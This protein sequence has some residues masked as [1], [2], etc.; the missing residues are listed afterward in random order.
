MLKYLLV[1]VSLALANPAA[2]ADAVTPVRAIMDVA[3]ALW[4]SAD[5]EAGD[6]FDETHIGNFSK[7]LRALYA[8]ATKHPAFDTEDG[9]GSPFDYDPI[10]LGQDG[11]PLEELTIEPAGKDGSATDVVAR[12]KRFA[13]MEG[14]SEEERNALSEVHFLVVSESGR[15]VIADVVSG[16]DD[17]RY[18]LVETLKAIIAN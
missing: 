14:S 9:T 3:S 1:T 16:D 4:S 8:E 15:P 17:D 6:Y 5:G 2:A 11:C 13:C 12:F 10:I 18:S 7:D